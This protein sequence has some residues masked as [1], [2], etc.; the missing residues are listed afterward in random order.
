M[1][2]G[3]NVRV[4]T[5]AQLAALSHEIDATSTLFRHGYA[6][7]REYR[8]AARD[9]EAVFVCL[10]GGA[11]KLLKLSVG[12]TALEDGR[13]WPAQ[14]AMK[15][16][17]HRITQLDETVRSLIV[18]RRERSSVPGLITKLLDMTDGHGGVI[19]L[20]Q[21][22]ERYA[23]QGRFYNL[24]LLAGH[25]QPSEAPLDLWAELHEMIIDANPEY[26]EMLAGDEREE[27]RHAMNGLVASSCALWCELIHRSWLTGVLGTDAQRWSGQLDLGH[28]AA[29]PARV[30][31]CDSGP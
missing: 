29:L 3:D 23:V 6:I 30:R 22:L 14:A 7:L 27:A 8:F 21:T 12:L 11:E 28:A 24:D 5:P 2:R 9:A 26:M 15:N 19:V 20:L 31:I 10:A 18:A 16:A 4:L 13:G 17:G 1:H 25:V